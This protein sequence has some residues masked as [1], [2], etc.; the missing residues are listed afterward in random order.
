M[1]DNIKADS[2]IGTP[3]NR[4]AIERTII[5]EL[6]RQRVQEELAKQRAPGTSLAAKWFEALSRPFFLWLAS[7]LLLSFIPFIYATWRDGIHAHQEKERR[8]R[9]VERELEARLTHAR[10]RLKVLW[11]KS[12]YSEAPI[13]WENE[14]QPGELLAVFDRP[15]D[16]SEEGGYIFPEFSET[17]MD[18]LIWE[19]DFLLRDTG[20]GPDFGDPTMLIRARWDAA[21]TARINEDLVDDPA[22][23]LEIFFG[24]I[25]EAL[26]EMDK[27]PWTQTNE[28]DST[29][30]VGPAQ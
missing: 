4:E 26:D 29:A 12:R 25:N 8:L 15:A 19:R 16:G 28:W 11:D 23:Q 3:S 18:A 14:T 6:I 17:S 22:D 27:A 10:E 20:L 30:E 5:D 24:W 2:A 7:A 13:D 1:N 21:R 9:K